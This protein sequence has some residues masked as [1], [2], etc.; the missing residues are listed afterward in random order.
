MEDVWEWLQSTRELQETSYGI[1]YDE[2]TGDELADYI[3]WNA[4]A[5]TVEL[6]EFMQE[7]GWKPWA[8][9]RGWV[10]R[11][12]AADELVDIGHFLANLACAIGMTD[13]EWQKR[14]RRKQGINAQRQRD[15][16]TGLPE[17]G[18]T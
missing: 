10:N 11:D 8:H 17:A 9:P 7:C 15:G 13:E 18:V 16:Y 3:S 14:Y 5:L 12:E 4:T 6:G 2:L 1:D